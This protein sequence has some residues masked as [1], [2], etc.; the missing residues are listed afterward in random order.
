MDRLH[1]MSGDPEASAPMAADR[2]EELLHQRGRAIR[3]R[4]RIEA[5]CD[6]SDT[7][8]A[9]GKRRLG[10]MDT[11]VGDNPLVIEYIDESPS[12]DIDVAALE[13]ELPPT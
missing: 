7:D 2:A 1:V 9:G 5:S 13:G 12:D 8:R 6:G 10:T 11:P 3:R 4:L